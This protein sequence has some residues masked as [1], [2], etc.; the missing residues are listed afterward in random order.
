MRASRSM[1][2]T[3]SKSPA[4]GAQIC[5]RKRGSCTVGETERLPGTLPRVIS[6]LSTPDIS[7]SRTCAPFLV[8]GQ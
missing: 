3:R 1:G 7:P 8:V 4:V 2:R 5:Q 6:T